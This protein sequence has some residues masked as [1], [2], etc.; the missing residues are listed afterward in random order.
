[1][2]AEGDHLAIIGPSGIGK[3]TLARLLC[4]LLAPTGGWVRPGETVLI[5]QEAYVFSG[6]LRENLT[7]LNPGADPTGALVA[8]GA[9]DLVADLDAPINPGR[10]PAGRRQLIALA[11]SYLSPARIAVLDEATCHLDPAAEAVVER[12]F[13]ARPGALVVIAH[14]LGS[15]LRARRILVLD[16]QTALLGDH[17]SL[18]AC[19]PL[20]QQL[21]SFHHRDGGVRS[22]LSPAPAGSPRSSSGNPS[23]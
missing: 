14:R 11:R 2:V 5:P 9:G 22:T 7:Y 16:G 21:M 1:V 23:W 20:Y 17:E 12:A 3:S 19:S 8:L 6:T 4:G 10:L 13:A 18:L 15:A